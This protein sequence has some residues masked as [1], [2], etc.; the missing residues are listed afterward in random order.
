MS[1]ITSQD[2]IIGAFAVL[3]MV[4]FI[5]CTSC[6]QYKPSDPAGRRQPPPPPSP[7]GDPRYQ[8]SFFHMTPSPELAAQH[9]GP[10]RPSTE[11]EEE[12]EEDFEE[13][14]FCTQPSQKPCNGYAQT[15]KLENT[16]DWEKKEDDFT[17][18]EAGPPHNPPM[19][20]LVGHYSDAL[21]PISESIHVHI[22]LC[23][24]RTIID[25]DTKTDST[26]DEEEGEEEHKP[27]RSAINSIGKCSSQSDSL[28]HS[29][30][31]VAVGSPLTGS[32]IDYV[33]MA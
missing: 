9:S 4:F 8:H 2:W 11:N 18:I 6:W 31:N 30:E 26:T 25:S 23:L 5:G 1:Q 14:E 21:G 33:N 19:F 20:R 28:G 7:D 32:D 29:Y 16:R 10:R 27:P 3:V 12:S 22:R 17:V 24:C 15:Q 13:G